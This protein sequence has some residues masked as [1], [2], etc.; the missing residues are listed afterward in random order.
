MSNTN[1]VLIRP[2]PVQE[3]QP[4]E[5]DLPLPDVKIEQIQA[6]PEEESRPSERY[7][8]ELQPPLQLQARAC[9]GDQCALARVC[10]AVILVLSLAGWAA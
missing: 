1:E 3:D 7:A 5:I 6:I 9:I 4:V 10:N 2:E 8:P